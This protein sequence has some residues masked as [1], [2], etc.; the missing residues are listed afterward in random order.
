MNLIE[1]L[2]NLFSYSSVNISE[3]SI[4]SERQVRFMLLAI[5]RLK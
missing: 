3:E 2:V 5:E 1:G 4:P